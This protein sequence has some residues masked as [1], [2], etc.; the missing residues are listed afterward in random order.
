VAANPSVI[1]LSGF[2][3]VTTEYRLPSGDRI[4]VVFEKQGCW[5]GVEVKGPSSSEIDIARGMFQTVK[6]MAVRNADLK[7]RPETC[8]TTA[9]LVV[10]SKLSPTLRRL[11]DCLGIDVREGIAV[12][13]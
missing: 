2:E 12:P 1:G 5:V 6:Y 13:T 7:R 10:S 3:L 11:K 9:I 4:D 8:T